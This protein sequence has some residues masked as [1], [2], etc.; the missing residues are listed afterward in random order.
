[1][2][3]GQGT[4]RLYGDDGAFPLPESTRAELLSAFDRF[5]DLI[6]PVGAG[7]TGTDIHRRGL[8]QLVAESLHGHPS[9]AEF[10]LWRSKRFSVGGE[11]IDP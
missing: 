11:P 4:A 10:L 8:A 6:E 7:M 1:V 2:R 5:G 3:Q 9:G